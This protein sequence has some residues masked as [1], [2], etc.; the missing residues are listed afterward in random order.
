VSDYDL[1]V[2]GAG[3]AGA[4]AGLIAAR[5]GARVC[6]LDRSS[7]PRHKLCGDSVNP[8]A[9][10]TLARL[11]LAAEVESRGLPVDGMIVTGEGA[12]VVGLYPRGLRGRTIRRGDLD[13]ILLRSAIAAGCHFEPGVAV[14]RALLDD[15]RDA[16]AIRYVEI[17]R[18]SGMA[19]MRAQ[20][21]IAADGRRSTLGF[22]LGF[23]RHPERPRRWAIG[24]YFSGV[25]APDLAQASDGVVGE[26]HIR[27]DRYVGVAPIPDGLTNVCL[28]RPFVPGDSA[29]RDPASLLRGAIESD[30]AL[31]ERFAAATAVAEPVVLG[32][33]AVDSTGR[34]PI[35]GLL[36]AGD[37]AGF[38]DPMTGDGLNFAIRG[39]ELA[40]EAALRA[41][42]HGWRAVHDAHAAARA[43]AFSVKWRFN[44]ALRSVVASRVAMSLGGVGARLAP[45]AL[46]AIVA[47][48]G[49]CD[50]A[51]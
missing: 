20:A 29:I 30:P 24:G 10:A 44:R 7:F 21:I 11:G 5:A 16:P 1:L 18:R 47:R 14:R 45:A 6:I 51:A 37:S 2:I 28:V 15:T 13:W 35:T 48:A 34:A 50:Q 32:P 39:G 40:A 4:V 9:M 23:L 31:R 12:S 22:A 46:R 17:A 49:D 19:A 42:A 43:D 38:I 36:F 27:K 3:P 25:G 26:M 33:L 8:G 41:L